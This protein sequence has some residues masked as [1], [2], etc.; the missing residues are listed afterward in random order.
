MIFKIFV[1]K[2]PTQ[3]DSSAQLDRI[4]CVQNEKMI[5]QIKIINKCMQDINT[6]QYACELSILLVEANF[7]FESGNYKFCI[8]WGTA[9]DLVIEA[10]DRALIVFDDFPR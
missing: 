3:S 9:V 10:R 2:I 6:Y 8:S 1:T 5:N 7:S 4:V